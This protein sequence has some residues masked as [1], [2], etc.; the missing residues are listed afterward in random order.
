MK[1][2]YHEKTLEELRD[3]IDKA[4]FNGRDK[5]ME[6]VYALRMISER[7]GVDEANR[8]IRDF[9]LLRLGY[10]E[11]VG[12]EPVGPAVNPRDLIDPLDRVER[13]P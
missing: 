4:N 13:E 6:I 7:H 2:E 9:G 3:V 1:R 8:A 10:R 12:E 11:Q 5:V